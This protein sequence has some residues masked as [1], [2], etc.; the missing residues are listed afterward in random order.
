MEDF[1]VVFQFSQVL[2]LR[3]SLSVSL[4]SKSDI[5]GWGYPSIVEGLHSNT[6]FS[7]PFLQSLN[8]VLFSTFFSVNCEV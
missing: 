3:V 6:Y 4:L 7:F 5:L 1:S 2:I 8:L